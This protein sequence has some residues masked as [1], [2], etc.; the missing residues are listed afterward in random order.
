MFFYVFI[1]VSFLR[2]NVLFSEHFNINNV[3]V[4]PHGY[5]KIS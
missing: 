2:F 5:A 4:R 1:L 3:R